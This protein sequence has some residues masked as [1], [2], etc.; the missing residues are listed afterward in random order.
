MENISNSSPK[1]SNYTSTKSSLSNTN[2]NTNQT[3]KSSISNHKKTM[4]RKRSAAKILNIVV[5]VLV[6][7]K[8]IRKEKLQKINR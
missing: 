6:R 7:T 3:A 8:L 2:S 5:R 4:E 1:S